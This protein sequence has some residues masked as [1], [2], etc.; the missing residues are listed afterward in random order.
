MLYLQPEGMADELIAAIRVTQDLQVSASW[1]E[2]LK[3]VIYIDL[4]ELLSEELGPFLKDPD[5]PQYTR[6]REGQV[7]FRKFITDPL[8]QRVYASFYQELSLKQVCPQSQGAS[9]HSTASCKST[10]AIKSTASSKASTASADSKVAADST[11]ADSTAADSTAAYS[12]AADST[13]AD[14]AASAV[15][16]NLEDSVSVTYWADDDVKESSTAP[17]LKLQAGSI[18]VENKLSQATERTSLLQLLQLLSTCEDESL[19]L[20]IDNLDAPFWKSL[21]IPEAYNHRTKFLAAFFNALGRC[22]KVF[23][24]IICTAKIRLTHSIDDFVRHDQQ[25]SMPLE[26]DYEYG[27]SAAAGTHFGLLKRLFEISQQR[28]CNKQK[29]SSDKPPN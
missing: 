6:A 20:L 7:E 24:H 19:V 18:G 17:K 28:P 9:A 13:A 14:S 26:L 1:H 23:R 12:T 22:R 3:R 27:F 5:T 15:S 21:H 11:A 2:P 25:K 10:A 16:I 8:A 29:Q 4:E